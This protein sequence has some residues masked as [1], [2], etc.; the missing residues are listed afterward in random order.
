[1]FTSPDRNAP[2]AWITALALLTVQCGPA[3][4]QNFTMQV[5]NPNPLGLGNFVPG[6]PGGPEL[7]APLGGE[8]KG[9]FSYGVGASILYDSN[10][11]L[12]EDN[13]RSDLSGSIT[14]SVSYT[15]DPEGGAPVS[16]SANYAPS[17]NGYLDNPELGGVNHSGNF[18]LLLNGSKTD[19]SLFGS[20]VQSSAPD[21]LSGGFVENGTVMT[22]GLQASREIGPR[23]TLNTAWTASMS[24]YGSDSGSGQ[25]EGST[26]Y[27]A[28]VGGDW[29]ATELLSFGPSVRYTNTQSDNSET[30]DAWA[31]LFTANYQASERIWLSASIGPE[32]S[33]TGEDSSVDVT[34]NLAATY[35]INERWT[36][37][38]QISSGTVPAPDQANY[39]I[40][41]VTLST[42]LSRQF[43]RCAV[44]GG[45]NF[46]FSGYDD[47]GNV[48]S[49]RDNE[50]T[51][52]AFLSYSRTLFT[53]RLGFNSM[54]GY[55]VNDGETDWEQFTASTGLNL[56]F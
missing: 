4:A 38:N 7:N 43:T 31:L 19:V 45:L 40:Q 56:S 1:M 11:Y 47:V 16:F 33:E 14:P 48:T 30:R 37:R 32:F 46:S 18:A 28:S 52:G 22:G 9:A 36:W 39:M 21:R 8:I 17:I 2:N 51:V 42:I 53:E 49:N 23:T 3:F 29:K 27:S 35:V 44:S 55:S 20:L 54:I 12:E 25:Y 26:I 34:G 15:S 50:Q 5:T 10:V 41:D 6:F 24:D 13:E